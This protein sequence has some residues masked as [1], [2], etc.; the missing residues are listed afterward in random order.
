MAIIQIDDLFKTCETNHF[1]NID[2]SVLLNEKYFTLE[3]VYEFGLNA[4][5][6]DYHLFHV[7]EP[8]E[9]AVIFKMNNQYYLTSI[10]GCDGYRDE[11]GDIYALYFDETSLLSFLGQHNIGNKIERPIDVM[12]EKNL[13]SSMNGVT[14]YIESYS[15]D[16]NHYLMFLGTN[17]SDSYYPSGNISFN[18]ATLLKAE[19]F[20]EKQYLEKNVSTEIKLANKVKL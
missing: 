5:S 4:R 17:N 1:K 20:I 3:A 8:S 14:F 18:D 2:D 13:E 11:R 6:E 10:N 9:E 16:R 19:P 15:T 7:Y 12:L